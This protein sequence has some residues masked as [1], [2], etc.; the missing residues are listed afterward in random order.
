MSKPSNSSEASTP[1]RTQRPEPTQCGDLH[2]AKDDVTIHWER[3]GRGDRE[4]VVLLNGIGMLT[5]SWY[6]SV[7]QIHPD[8]DVLLYDYP[9]QGASSSE[10]KPYYIHRLADYLAAVLDELGI[11]KIHCVGVSYGGFVG[12]EFGRRYPERLHTQ[13]LSGILLSREKLFD[14]YQEISLQFYAGGPE[15][16]DLYTRYMYEKTFG[17]QFVRQLGDKI[18]KLRGR[19]FD[20]YKDRTRS[21]ARLTEAQNLFFAN[22]DSSQQGYRAVKAPTLILAGEEDRVVPV[23]M[24]A[25]LLELYDNSRMWVVP[26][27]AHITYLERPEVFWPLL[28][29]L[30]TDKDLAHDAQGAVELRAATRT[31]ET[32]AADAAQA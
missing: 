19:F 14:M 3:F 15:L 23:W 8:F 17:E 31:A 20:N 18:D 11:E 16:F 29:K 21:L 24:Q 32:M 9:G 28:R 1:K 26:E 6:T 25:K 27:C 7:P 10:D 4:T 12:A 2:I 13:T 22:I 5:Q 30:M